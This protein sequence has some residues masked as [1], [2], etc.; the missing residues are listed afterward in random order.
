MEEDI[1]KELILSKLDYA[2]SVVKDLERNPDYI[3]YAEE[4][5]KNL[6]DLLIEIEKNVKEY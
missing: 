6:V 2:I 5:W 3:N 1:E 4:N